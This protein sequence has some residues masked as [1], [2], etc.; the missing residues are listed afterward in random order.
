MDKYDKLTIT[1]PKKVLEDFRKFCEETGLN[2]SSRIAVLIRD[3]LLKREI[4]RGQAV[5]MDFTPEQKRK[6]R[7]EVEEMMKK[8]LNK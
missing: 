4:A 8:R 5:V 3:D 2:M 6:M 7:K 1:L